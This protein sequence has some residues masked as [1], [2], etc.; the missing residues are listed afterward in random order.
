MP[1]NICLSGGADG[2]DLQWGMTAGMIGHSVIHWSFA[3]HNSSAPEH[4]L[5]E[6]NDEQLIAAEQPVDRARKAMGR[7]KSK[8]R[9]VNNLLRRNWYQVQ[10]AE[11]VYAVVEELEP[12]STAGG[13]GYAV[14]MFLQRHAFLPC[15]CYVFDQSDGEWY[16]WKGKWE[17]IQS[18]PKPYGVWAGI[19]TRELTVIGKKALRE[20]MGYDPER[21]NPFRSDAE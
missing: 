8:S 1:E 6:L 19:G 21:N 12:Q 2:S 13:T 5:I 9:Y 16:A 20:L 15:E 14:T 10:H 18:P 7:G 11:R 17:K 3:G 4:E